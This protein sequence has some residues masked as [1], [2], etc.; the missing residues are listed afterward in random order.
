MLSEHRHS[1][2]HILHTR[3]QYLN[4]QHTHAVAQ[5]QR[6]RHP[7]VGYLV[8]LLLVGLGLSVGL[9]ETQLLFPFS[10]PGV[11]LLFA[12]VIVALLWGTLPALF[13]VLLSLLVLDYFYVPPFGVLGGYGWSGI[14]QLFTFAGAGI[15][16]AILAHQ[17]EVAR[18]RAL[19]AERE[20]A[21]RANELAATF[22]A[23]SD[24]V[25][26]YNSQGQILSFNAATRRLFGL[27][28]FPAKDEEQVKQEL[29]LQAVYH[30][31]HG[32]TLPEKQRP[33]FRILK[34]SMFTGDNAADVLVRTP[35]GRDV[36]LNMSG[37]PIKSETGTIER[38]VLIYRDVTARR[39]LEQRTSEALRALLAMAEILVQFPEHLQ[40]GEDSTVP[41]TLS[42]TEQ[43]GQRVVE[44]TRSVVE[45]MHVVMLSI[46]LEE[47]I[48]RPVAAVGF[49]Q[50]QEQQWR[51]RLTTSS[52]LE[53]YIGSEEL[54][55]HL[56]N[57][58]VII[59]DGMTLPLHTHA[60]P[61]YVGTVLVAPIRVGNRLV[62]LLCID[63]GSR[64]HTYRSHE[65]TLL[66][67][68]ARLTALILARAQL[69][70]EHAEAQA[71]ERALRETN[72]RME[73]FLGIICHEL[74]TPLTVMRGSLQLAERKVKR[75]V[76]TEA[77]L[78]DEM[79]R[80]APVQ[81]LM[82]RARNQI[83]VQDRLVNDLLDASRVQAQTLRLL[84]APC[85]LVSIV[86]EAVEDQRQMAPDRTLHIQ[87]PAQK[88]VVV[89]A[90][91]DRLVQVVTN[92]LT[93]ALKYSPSDRPVDVCLS[94]EGTMVKVS[95]QDLGPGLSLK[96]QERVWERF[97]RVPGI[98][99]QSGS[100]TSN[101]G[102]GV[103]LYV[104]RTLIEKHGGQVGIQSQ[105]KEGAT[106][107]FTL[108]LAE[109]DSTDEKP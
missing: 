51:E 19:V 16:I 54:L 74:K 91:A 108:P 28:S 10:F 96:E 49:T 1:W 58:E 101:V 87:L 90:D 40:S 7:L 71:N 105:P 24:S 107:W 106:F 11:L 26:V 36:V 25:V 69:Q 65:I 63:D 84:L 104:C 64:E 94:V 93:N 109:Q 30:D 88:E 52:H 13:T 98:E 41:P 46:V 82:E 44:L 99:V 32:Q 43:V 29:L 79:R 2:Q 70:R 53:S 9:V 72:R 35:D 17:R 60:L 81:A 92:L 100:G 23:M 68:I 47:D 67:T 18:V 78:P 31:E 3:L 20:A 55:A 59:L 85:D 80:F 6:W 86:Q 34:G 66:Q 83:V 97:Y 56:K 57:D 8:G 75:L 77:L 45:S 62:G 76:A 50:Q 27:H 95:V 42:E 15:I 102:L 4:G 39:R 73:E 5:P 12:S 21:L 14:L 48:V 103:G 89:C 61:Y 33:L 38:A 37:A 22:E